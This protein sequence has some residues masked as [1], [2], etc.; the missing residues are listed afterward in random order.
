MSRGAAVLLY[1]TDFTFR[2][3]SQQQVPQSYKMKSTRKIKK[4]LSAKAKLKATQE[5]KVSKDRFD[6][7]PPET[8]LLAFRY[9][10]RKDHLQLVLVS[11][12]FR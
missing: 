12:F 9:L 7:V 11:S 5:V 1:G 6:S 10:S 3:P 8:W 2:K 4:L